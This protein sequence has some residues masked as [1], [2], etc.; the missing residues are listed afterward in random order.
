M[1]IAEPRI[2]SDHNVIKYNIAVGK[3]KPTT[4]ALKLKKG[5]LQK[6]EAAS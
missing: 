5:E 4:E 6:T 2:N 1:N 3:Y